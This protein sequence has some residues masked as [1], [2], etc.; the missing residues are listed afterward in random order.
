MENDLLSLS[1]LI[2]AI[3]SLPGI[4]KKSAKKIAYFLI[5]QD[6]YYLNKFID[7]LKNAKNDL[8]LCTNCNN[9]TSNKNHICYV[10]T[11]LNR[12]NKQLCVVSTVEDLETIE[13]SNKYNG[14][15][16]VLWD[17]ANLKKNEQLQK[18]DWNK[19]INLIKKNNIEEVILATNLTANGMYTTKLIYERLKNV[20]ENLVFSRIG[21]GLPINSSIDYADSLTIGYSITN[22]TKFEK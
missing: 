10:C 9:L 4:G 14:L 3:S 8:F 21:F 11:D 18:V 12:N 16:F 19:I 1:Y 20:T 7:I 17:E 6:E 2:D 15:Y 5:N 22:R 13:E